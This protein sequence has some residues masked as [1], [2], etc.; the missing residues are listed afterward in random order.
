M[1]KMWY[2]GKNLC[3]HGPYVWRHKVRKSDAFPTPSSFVYIGINNLLL[4]KVGYATLKFTKRD[5]LNFNEAAPILGYLTAKCCLPSC[6]VCCP[7]GVCPMPRSVPTRNA[8]K[9]VKKDL[10]FAFWCW[11]RTSRSRWRVLRT[12]CCSLQNWICGRKSKWKSNFLYWRFPR[13]CPIHPSSP[14]WQDPYIYSYN[15]SG[16]GSKWIPHR[17]DPANKL[18]SRIDQFH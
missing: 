3:R 17:V 1:F 6:L 14:G 4:I 18:W 16:P 9:T 10:G 5:T 7:A 2:L 12:A 13:Q 15:T 11:P 8:D